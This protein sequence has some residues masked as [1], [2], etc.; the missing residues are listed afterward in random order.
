MPNLWYCTSAQ[1]KEGAIDTELVYSYAKTNRLAELEEFISSP[2]VAQ[3]Q[4]IADRCFNEVCGNC[5]FV[6]CLASPQVRRGVGLLCHEEGS[7]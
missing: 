1:V 7:Q 4:Y 5:M 2:N 6:S 3:I